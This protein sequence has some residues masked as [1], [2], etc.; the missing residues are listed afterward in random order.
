MAGAADRPTAEVALLP[1]PP[2]IDGI[3]G[4]TEWEG[5]AVLDGRFVQVE[6]EFG[7][8]SD[9]GNTFFTKFSWVF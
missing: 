4:D 5:S 1:A 6:P 7:E 2:E 8:A 9:Q 3:I